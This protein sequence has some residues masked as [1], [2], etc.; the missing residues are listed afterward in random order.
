MKVTRVKE[1]R[2][3]IVLSEPEI[4]SQEDVQA[5]QYLIYAPN[6]N[7]ALNSALSLVEQEHPYLIV[8]MTIIDPMFN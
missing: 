8:L 2:I 1:Y 3:R 6:E 7:L 4:T 5:V